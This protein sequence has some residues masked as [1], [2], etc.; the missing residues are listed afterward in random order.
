MDKDR[1]DDQIHLGEQLLDRQRRRVH[2]RCTAAV[3]AGVGLLAAVELHDRA[4]GAQVAELM[5]ENGVLGRQLDD[6]SLHISPPFVITEQ[7]IAT[8]AEVIADALDR[9]SSVLAA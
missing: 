6:G 8:V 5:V 9:V 4:L 3:R 7:E 1:A 2:G